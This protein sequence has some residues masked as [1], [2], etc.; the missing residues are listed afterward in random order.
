MSRLYRDADH[1][2]EGES[3]IIESYSCHKYTHAVYNLQV[4]DGSNN[5]IKGRYVVEMNAGSMF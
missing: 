5:D 4:K 3:T 2:K 1:A